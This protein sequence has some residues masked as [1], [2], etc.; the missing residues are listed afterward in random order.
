MLYQ[1]KNAGERLKTV[2]SAIS[3]F[4]ILISNRSAADYCV[5]CTDPPATYRCFLPKANILV[6]WQITDEKAGR[7]CAKVLAKT[8]KH[9]HCAVEENARKPCDGAERILS[10]T[11]IERWS[12][13][14]QEPQP[15]SLLEKSTSAMSAAASYAESQ[16]SNFAHAA[17]AAWTCTKTLFKE[18]G[19]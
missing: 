4:T 17:K 13:G 1:S 11:D 14:G 5:I 16:I 8:E 9:N 6:R 19:S 3:V 2:C 7:F 12:A 18:C 15:P 10:L